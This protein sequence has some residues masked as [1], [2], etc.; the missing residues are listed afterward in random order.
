MALHVSREQAAAHGVPAAAAGS[1]E[2]GER[3]TALPQ[4]LETV[5][6]VENEGGGYVV[7]EFSAT[8]A[9]ELL[10]L[11]ARLGEV[12]LPPYIH[13]D[14]PDAAAPDLAGQAAD[15]ERYQTVF[16]RVPG[17]VA[18]PTAGLHFTPQV[19]AALRARGIESVTVTLHV[20]PG[21]LHAAAQ[22]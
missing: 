7:V 9:E 13:R 12:P 4:A 20:G 1:S 16:A 17:S 6:V 10:A 8:T 21:D 2:R 3:G 18:A 15:R 14:R 11:L 22:R 19:L 5:Q